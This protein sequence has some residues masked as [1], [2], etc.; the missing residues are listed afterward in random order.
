MDAPMTLSR[1]A[2]LLPMLALMVGA[3]CAPASAHHALGPTTAKAFFKVEVS[4]AHLLVR[5]PLA[6]LETVGFPLSERELDLAK[7]GPAIDGV[8]AELRREVVIDE[9]GDALAATQAIG[10]LSLPSDRSFDAYESAVSHVAKDMRGGLPIYAEQGFFDAHLTYPIRSPR[11]QFAIRSNALPELGSYLKL[12]VRFIPVD[13]APRLVSIT[14]QSGSVRLNPRWYDVAWDFVG[15]G[16]SFLVTDLE[17]L[18]FALCLLAP[19]RDKRFVAPLIGVFAASALTTLAAFGHLRPPTG[20]WL[21]LLAQ[22]GVAASIVTMAL[23]RII[24]PLG[25]GRRGLA[26]LAGLLV[27]LECSFAFRDRLQF[28]GDHPFVALTWFVVGIALALL[29]VAFVA[30][31]VLALLLRYVFV[32]RAGMI[33]LLAVVAL[34]AWPWMLE[35]GE[36]LSR[37]HL[38]PTELGAVVPPL[39][40]GVVGGAMLALFVLRAMSLRLGTIARGVPAG[41]RPA[42]SGE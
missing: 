30:R 14:S 25:R 12:A 3:W 2:S 7:A 35:R 42:T 33:V 39:L 11:S 24:A 17:F 26:W 31:P 13:G 38:P 36:L 28:A 8:L 15:R 18:L 27:G 1:F 32:G 6:A 22:A 23:A 34:I 20:P 21:P 9:G 4:E 10:R 41:W 16:T 40:W 5:L 37:A 29:V 19:S